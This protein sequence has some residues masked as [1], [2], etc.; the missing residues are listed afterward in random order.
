MDTV[1]DGIWALLVRPRPANDHVGLIT[2]DV[3]APVDFSSSGGVTVVRGDLVT[4]GFEFS[5][6]CLPVFSTVVVVFVGMTSPLLTRGLGVETRFCRGRSSSSSLIKGSESLDS[7]ELFSSSSKK[8]SAL[9]DYFC[10]SR[11][12]ERR[13]HKNKNQ[14]FIILAVFPRSV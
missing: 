7:S 8:I 1:D 12:I 11:R 9:V 14:I 3:V 10:S 6:F 13:S 4:G 5:L 2:S